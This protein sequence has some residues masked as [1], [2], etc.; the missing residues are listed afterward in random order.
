MLESVSVEVDVACASTWLA[1]SRTE[2]L[3]NIIVLVELTYLG[4]ES[5][6]ERVNLLSVETGACLHR[7]K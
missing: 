6:G 4:Y 2:M 7:F 3:E 5:L 1:R